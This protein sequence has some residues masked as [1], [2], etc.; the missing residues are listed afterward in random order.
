VPDGFIYSLLWN[1]ASVGS[2]GTS[3]ELSRQGFNP[4]GMLT[5]SVYLKGNFTGTALDLNFRN[6]AG[7]GADN[8]AITT[9]TDFGNYTDWTRVTIPVD[10]T[11][12]AAHANNKM[13]NIEF[14]NFPVGGK[15][16]GLQL[17]AGDT[18]TPFEHRSYGDE[19]ARCQRYFQ[20][21]GDG[22]TGRVAA[23]G[24]NNSTTA[25]VLLPLLCEMRGTPTFTQNGIGKLLDVGVA[26]H[27]VTALNLVGESTSKAV[28]LSVAVASSAAGQGDVAILGGGALDTTD[29]LFDA[30]L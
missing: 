2:L 1:R 28:S 9:K 4:Y 21:F 16:T 5:C 19:L 26:W 25:D 24:W 8:V 3:V 29:Y 13:L 18:A 10:C 7:G 22:G 14:G 12:I 30:E 23:G 27:P 11:G 6:Y 17:E 15:I 20:R